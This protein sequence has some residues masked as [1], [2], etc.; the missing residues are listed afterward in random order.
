MFTV[1]QPRFYGFADAFSL[2]WLICWGELCSEATKHGPVVVFLCA[3]HL[4]E[5]R[6]GMTIALGAVS[7]VSNGTLCRADDRLPLNPCAGVRGATVKPT[8]LHQ[9]SQHS[10]FTKLARLV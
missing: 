5:L 2:F 1:Y 4:G 6:A 10:K 9:L 3:G 7:A 8:H